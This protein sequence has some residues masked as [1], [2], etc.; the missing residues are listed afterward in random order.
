MSFVDAVEDLARSAGLEVPR[1]DT[2]AA[3]S[4]AAALQGPLD[5]LERAQRFFVRQLRVHASAIEYL[6]GRRVS[7]ETARSFGIGFAPE[8]WDALSVQFPKPRE[9]IDAGLLI[10]K[11]GGGVYDRFRNRLM[12]PIRDGR[13]RVIAFGGRTLGDDP[14]KYLN[15]PE[16]PVFHKGS[17]LFG[18]YE[19]RKANRDVPYLLVV[20]GYMDV[21]ALFEHGLT[22]AVATLGTATT[23]DQVKLLFRSAP[24]V[25]FCFDGDAAG[26]RAAHKA[27]ETCLP[28][29]RGDREVRFLFLPDGHDPDTLVQEIGPDMFQQ[30]ID[31]AQPLSEYLFWVLEQGLDMASLEGRARC[32]EKAKPYL[33]AMKPSSIKTLIEGAMAS[34]IGVSFADQPPSAPAQFRSQESDAGERARPIRRAL[35]LLMDQPAVAHAVDHLSQLTQVDVPGM[36]FLLRV[37]DYF[38]E[39]PDAHAGHLIQHFSGQPEAQWLSR[40]AASPV[41]LEPE[42]IAAEFSEI[43]ERLRQPAAL[44]RIRELQARA[45]RL[46]EAERAELMQLM[47]DRAQPV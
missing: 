19:V 36:D 22:L 45:D 24:R 9:A 10:E 4:S 39:H 42:Q 16:T 13:G 44:G 47:R 25:V 7:G 31:A 14:A 17:N 23:S 5:A 33:A 41:A 37:I 27:L 3:V 6:K 18:L 29:L 34:R 40:L 35:Q 43:L 1:D 8:S 2:A 20:E 32:A 28:Q 30:R 46:S 21:V 11:D 15:S 38:Q 12:F 26:R